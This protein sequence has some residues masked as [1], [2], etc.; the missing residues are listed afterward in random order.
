MPRSRLHKAARGYAQA[1]WHVFPV[2]PREKRPLTQHGVLDATTDL[3]QIDDWWHRWPEANIGVACGQRSGIYVVD[4]DGDEG[5][6]TALDWIA[7]GR[8]FRALWQR[9]PNGWHAIFAMPAGTLSNSAKKLG[10]GVDSRGDGG[11]ILVAPSVHPSGQRYHFPD[12]HLP[13]PM[14]GWLLRQL[15]PMPQPKA[16]SPTAGVHYDGDIDAYARAALEAEVHA[17]GNAASGTRNDTLNVAAFNLGQLVAIGVLDGEQ[18]AEALFEASE[19][20]DLVADDGA[21]SAH[22]TIR[23]GL[24]AGQRA[25]REVKV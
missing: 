14:P 7:E 3:T 23:S 15:R 12:H 19:A 17:V 8:S 13:Y 10:P 6:D 5:R 4:L 22:K 11:Y 24:T 25:P 9:T 2:R 21:G 18:V 16:N 1:G 20:C